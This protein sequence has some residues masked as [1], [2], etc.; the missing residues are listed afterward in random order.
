MSGSRKEWWHASIAA[1][2]L[3]YAL[4]PNFMI[5]TVVQTKDDVQ[6]EALL[7]SETIWYCGECMSCVT[8]CPRKNAPGL[9]IMALRSLSQE[10]GFFTD[11]EKGRQQLALKRTVGE[12]ILKR[13]YCVSPH[14]V[15]FE[16]HP[17][18]G[19]VWKWEREKSEADGLKKI[20]ITVS[21][22]LKE[23]SKIRFRNEFRKFILFRQAYHT[24]LTKTSI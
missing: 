14:I 21:S 12:N 24:F 7:R 3:Q 19:P 23:K 1:L 22:F 10:E 8:R 17:E 15:T 16:D 13:G 18:T 4:R 5:T 2:G 20:G 6:I 11:S 9:V